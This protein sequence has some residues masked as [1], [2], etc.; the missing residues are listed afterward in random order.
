MWLAAAAAMTTLLLALALGGGA[1]TS[2]LPGLT[3]PGAATRWGLPT[4]RLIMDAA[5]V[6]TVGFLLLAVLIPARKGD[7][8]GESLRA[9][10]VASIGA[11]VWASA[12]AVAH[13]LTLSDLV[14]LPLGQALQGQALMSFTLSVELGQAYAVVIL[15]ALVLIP[16]ARLVLRRGGALAVLALGLATLV[17]PALTGHSS[18]GDYHHSAATSLIVHVLTVSLWVG[19]LLAI[20]FYAHGRGRELARVVESYSP[21][22]FGAAVLVAASGFI[23]AVVRLGTPADLFTSWYGLFVLAKSLL[24]VALIGA[25][26]WHRNRTLP[27]LRAGKPGAFARIAAAEVVI[28]AS[29]IGLAVGLSRTPTPVPEVIEEPSLARQLLGYPIPPEPNAQRL[30]TEVYPDGLFFILCTAMVVFY[31]AGVQRLRRRG[32]SWPV[33]RTIAWL[34]GVATLAF[35][36]MS[37]LMTYGMTMLSVHMTQHMIE[38][39]LVPVFL[40]LGAPITLAL[41]AMKPARRGETGPRETLLAIVHSRV[42]R[43]LTH[44]LVVFGIFVTAAPLVYFSSLFELAMYHHTG[45]LLMSLHFILGGYLFYEVIIGVDPLPKRPP[46]LARF[47]MVLAAAGFHAFFGVA[48]MQATRLIAGDWYADLGGDITWLPDTLADQRV[49]GQI[50]WGFGEIP[51]LLVLMVLVFQW[52]RADERAAR[53][54]DRRDTSQELAK[55]NEYLASLNRR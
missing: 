38:A 24:F 54:R 20:L 31:L 53:R 35:S 8:T 12:A 32:D 45:H 7:L 26:A 25:G 40:V 6:L 46:Y 16:T 27:L 23:N 48:L 18:S 50:T 29:T 44:P 39:M 22:A 55:Y 10:R 47:V 14:G 51:A 13:L 5:A 19:G 36:T 42:L 43:F 37:G 21:L 3:D 41:R 34:L 52:A 33:G 11:V 1:V 4:A 28:M 15:L 17:P 2:D 30:I 49:A 9:L